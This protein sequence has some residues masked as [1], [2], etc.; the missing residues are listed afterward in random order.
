MKLPTHIEKAKCYDADNN[1]QY[2]GMA[3]IT[4]PSI[5]KKKATIEGM[6]VM[7]TIENPTRRALESMT[8]SSAFRGLTDNNMELLNGVKS[9]DYR[10]ALNVYDTALK[11]NRTVQ[12]RVAVTGPVSTYDLGEA[13]VSNAMSVQADIEVYNLKVWL[14][15]K[16]K[17][18]FDKWNE[19]YR[20]NGIDVASDVDE[21]VD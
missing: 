6:G 13:E 5:E 4:L 2:V 3:S 8:L 12:I 18:E 19:I 20:I 16:P 9:L 1:M 11:V 15:K 21:A 17:I 14:D 10:A 7:G